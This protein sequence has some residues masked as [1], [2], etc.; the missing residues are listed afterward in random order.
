M[1]NSLI[2][3]SI[4]CLSACAA[5]TS[6][7]VSDTD[8]GSSGRPLPDAGDSRDTG[9]P[10]A[11][12]GGSDATSGQDAG[13]DAPQRPDT[14]A[15]DSGGGSDACTAS[16]LDQAIQCQ[17]EANDLFV[18]GFCDCF[19]ETG[20][21]GDRGACVA[22]QPGADAFTPDSCTRTAL[23]SD[24]PAAVTNS[25]CYAAAAR[26]LAAC[27]AVCPPT[28][29][30]FNACFDAVGAEFDR[31]DAALPADLLATLL[32]CDDEPVEPPTD[33]TTAIDAL[34]DQR[35][36][37]ITQY[38]TCY[39]TTEFGGAAAC[40]TA[41]ESRWDPGFSDC[42]QTAFATDSAAALPFVNCLAESFLIAE[43]SCLECPGPADF[44]YE[45]CSDLSIDIQFCF[46]EADPTLQDT[47]VACSP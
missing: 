14:S 33:V 19:T 18:E 12:D 32:A 11:E 20:Y 30:D 3:V 43:S 39:G 5:T 31:C 4:F 45:L 41:L 21:D 9:N 17:V 7:D 25:L 13:A 40:R 37:Y 23:L 1:R 46:N 8:T 27:I 16:T 22:D 24:E 44:E 34:T 42:E 28:E 29:A 47:L 35:S 2:L 36:S 10:S 6:D 15:P 38:C 26:E